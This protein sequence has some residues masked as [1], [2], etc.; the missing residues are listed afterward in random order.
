[1]VVGVKAE[2]EILWKCVIEGHRLPVP[3]D[4]VRLRFIFYQTPFDICFPSLVLSI[5]HPRRH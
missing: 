1:M 3:S 5:W 2:V 4:G